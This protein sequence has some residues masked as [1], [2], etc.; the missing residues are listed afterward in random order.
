[1]KDVKNI[2]V[3]AVTILVIIQLINISFYI[4]IWI[5]LSAIWFC[6]V[7]ELHDEKTEFT[8]FEYL[9]MPPM[10][11]YGFI[12]LLGDIIFGEG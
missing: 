10:I 11:L 8:V 12:V 1:M 4:G 9:L 5:L 7:E 6:I 2:V 3:G